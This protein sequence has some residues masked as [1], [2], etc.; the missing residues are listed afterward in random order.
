MFL[1]HRSSIL[2]IACLIACMSITH[3]ESLREIDGVT[4]IEVKS[5]K[6]AIK[7]M[8]QKDW[9]GA[10]P[11][12]EAVIAEDS[13][14]DIALFN[15][16]VTLEK[17]GRQD[18]ARSFYKRALAVDID[19]VYIEALARV[20][21]ETRDSAAMASRLIRCYGP[22]S[23]GYRY[24]RAGLWN[25]AIPHLKNAYD[26]D[27][28]DDAACFN[29]AVAYEVIGQHDLALEHCKQAIVLKSNPLY[30]DFQNLL[31]TTPKK[32]R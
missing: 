21:G 7:L 12:L 23:F 32:S 19:D 16:G 20:Q 28:M 5:V 24:A 29:L 31:S 11:L 1:T 2:C 4:V 18:E 22:C 14:N 6:P 17:L 15:M 9:Q 26:R 25:D 10:L 30:I 27:P 8:K 13:S 3:A